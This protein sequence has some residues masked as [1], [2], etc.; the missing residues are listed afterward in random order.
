V[1]AICSLNNFGYHC[2]YGGR[3]TVQKAF[4]LMKFILDNLAIGDFHP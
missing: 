2:L 3:Q 1:A 4:G